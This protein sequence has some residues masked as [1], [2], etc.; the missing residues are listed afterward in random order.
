MSATA[1]AI[2]RFSALGKKD[3]YAKDSNNRIA[4]FAPPL[5][6]RSNS[7]TGPW[8]RIYQ[9]IFEGRMRQAER[10]LKDQIRLAC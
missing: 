5:T 9:T 1:A 3:I 8:Q 10:L 2:S 6:A 7:P 4:A